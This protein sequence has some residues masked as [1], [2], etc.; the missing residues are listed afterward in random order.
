MDA[1]QL[2]MRTSLEDLKEK[3]EWLTATKPWKKTHFWCVVAIVLLSLLLVAMFLLDQPQAVLEPDI[4]CD[5]AQLLAE[6]ASLKEQLGA[7]RKEM[8]GEKME[9]DRQLDATNRT[10]RKTKLALEKAT[11]ARDGLQAQLA[12]A[13]QSFVETQERWKSCQAQ[14][15]ST[16]GKTTSLE[17]ERNSLKQENQRLR[18]EIDGLRQQLSSREREL[19]NE[20]WNNQQRVQ[21]WMPAE[22]RN[23]QQQEVAFDITKSPWLEI[24]AILLLLFLIYRFCLCQYDLAAWLFTGHGCCVAA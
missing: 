1:L 23:Y 19:E 13:N 10:L 12:A 22:Q 18:G 15:D 14:L 2:A 5:R 16:K 11:K 6:V 9:S 24:A 7:V 3:I 20:R 4:E 21:N 8:E 17:K